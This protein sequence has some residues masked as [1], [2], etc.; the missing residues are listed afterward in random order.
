MVLSE[1]CFWNYGSNS[2]FFFALLTWQH[3]FF[4]SPNAMD[5]HPNW[6]EEDR[7][8]P[9]HGGYLDAHFPTSFP[10]KLRYSRDPPVLNHLSQQSH[11]RPLSSMSLGWIFQVLL[12]SETDYNWG[13]VALCNFILARWIGSKSPKNFILLFVACLCL[14]MESS[15]WFCF[16]FCMHAHTETELINKRVGLNWWCK[17]W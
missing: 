17:N 15:L 8:L 6:R 4:F 9:A 11:H 12:A 3:H 7:F 13:C 1:F 14:Q 2:V 5:G 10:R 16:L